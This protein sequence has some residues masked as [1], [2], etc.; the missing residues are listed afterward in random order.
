MLGC[1]EKGVL[2]GI[3]FSPTPYAIPTIIYTL[4]YGDKRPEAMAIT[5]PP[6]PSTGTTP[7]S[8]PASLRRSLRT[9]ARRIPSPRRSRPAGRH[10][11]AGSA[12]ALSARGR[13][14]A[15]LWRRRGSGVRILL[16]SRGGYGLRGLGFLVCGLQWVVEEEGDVDL[17]VKSPLERAPNFVSFTRPAMKALCRVSL[18]RTVGR[19]GWARTLRR[20]LS[21][22]LRLASRGDQTAVFSP[23]GSLSP[24]ARDP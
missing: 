16:L 3:L 1:S 8:V 9:Q 19:D 24:R 2:S 18:V 21:R 12:G 4:R 11:S 6:A 23:Y 20:R 22:G 17:R 13:C 14:R 15:P 10:P 5:A 7:H